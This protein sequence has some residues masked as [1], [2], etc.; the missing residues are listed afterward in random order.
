MKVSENFTRAEFK[1]NCGRCDYDTIDCELIDVV[2][3]VR[4]HFDRPVT[5]TSGNRCPA[6]NKS[7]GGSTGSYH[8]RGRAA[9]IV[10]AGISSAEVFAYLDSKYPN[11]YGLGKYDAFTHV[12]TRTGKG[13]WN[14]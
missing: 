7:V 14:G 12:D 5:I 10:I 2:Q 1:C 4:T 11:K 8:I 6:Y 3:D 13:R 9:D